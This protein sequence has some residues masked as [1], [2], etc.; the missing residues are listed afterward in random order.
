MAEVTK[1]ADQYAKALFETEADDMQAFL[2]SYASVVSAFG[3]DESLKNIFLSPGLSS[4][5]KKEWM[6][7]SLSKI[8]GIHP[9]VNVFFQYIIDKRREDE[10]DSIYYAL[11]EKVDKKNGLVNINVTLARDFGSEK[12]AI[13]SLLKEKVNQNKNVFGL[14]DHLKEIQVT[15]QTDAGI[16]AG[17]ILRTGD[18][19]W[20]SSVKSYLGNWKK[21]VLSSKNNGVF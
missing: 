2:E 8:D 19:L 11:K 10:Y 3:Q 12:D 17:F 4:I 15:D 14:D 7:K 9:R 13:Y 5:E 21:R 1:T 16:I 20:D 18:Y 6:R